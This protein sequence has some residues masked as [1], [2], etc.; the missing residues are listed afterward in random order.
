LLAAFRRAHPGV[1]IRLSHDAASVLASAAADAQLDIAFIDGP[2][3]PA[4][5]TRTELGHDDLVL[6]V[7]QDD[8]LTE[9]GGIDLAD[10]ALRNRDFVDYRADSALR[11][12]I[13]VAC[14]A[15]A[16]PPTGPAQALLD[17]LPA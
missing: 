5:L 12:Q 1:T 6:A 9:R 14:A 3:D 7:P 2:A 4:R 10:P 11:A 17:L 16:H 15:A 13:D 8:P